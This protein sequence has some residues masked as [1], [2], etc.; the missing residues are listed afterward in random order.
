[1]RI[2]PPLS[3]PADLASDADSRLL[4]EHGVF[5]ERVDEASRR[6]YTALA[7][8]CIAIPALVV[9][10]S[11][12]SLASWA[13]LGLFASAAVFVFAVGRLAGLSHQDSRLRERVAKY[14]EREDVELIA[15]VRESVAAER[16]EFFVKL[17][18]PLLEAE[19][20]ELAERKNEP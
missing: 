13:A 11:G 8:A 14:L 16:Y 3:A 1:M 5:L 7:I 18:I 9:I 2:T 6:G 20:E 12:R 4:D 15:L 17:A 10:L 19:C